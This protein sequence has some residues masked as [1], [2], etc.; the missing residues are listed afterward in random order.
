MRRGLGP[1]A[2]SKLKLYPQ[3]SHLEAA[4]EHSGR[5]SRREGSREDPLPPGCPSSVPYDAGPGLS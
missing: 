2:E 5:E 3:S 1:V 4:A